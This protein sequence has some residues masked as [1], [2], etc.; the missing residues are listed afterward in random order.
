MTSTGNAAATVAPTALPTGGARLQRS[1]HARRT[2]IFEAVLDL[3]REGG[4]EAVQLRPV[5]ERS[6]VGL[7]TIYRYFGSRDR[8]ISAAMTVWV[9]RGWFDL[10]PSWAQGD[11]PAERLLT[12]YHRSWQ[13]WEQN[14]N[15]MDTFVNA[16]LAETDQE[17]GLAA[18]GVAVLVPIR[19]A[20]LADVEADYRHDVLNVLSHVYHSA[21]THVL[22]GE[23]DYSEV[24]TILEH[25]VKRLAQHPAMDG[26]RPPTWDYQPPTT[27][28]PP[29]KPTHKK[30]T[31]QKRK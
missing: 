27:N 31:T 1:Q 26:H 13:M 17:H 20:I 30:P 19:E 18:M 6:G 3:A 2:R 9:Q 25:T 16:V 28:K 7:D 4:Y 24:Y 8:L 15:M 23:L 29:K 21:M 5:S 14:P 12:L 22:R 11:T 10:A